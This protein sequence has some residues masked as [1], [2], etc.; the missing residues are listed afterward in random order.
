[1]P[2][3]KKRPTRARTTRRPPARVSRTRGKAR[4]RTGRAGPRWVAHGLPKLDERQRDV[5]AL[6]LVA[7]GV[8]MGFVLYGNWNGGRAGHGLA[9][10]LG[11]SIGR[12]RGL[13]PVALIVG[14]AA[15]LMAPVLP[16]LRPLRTGGACVFAAVTLALAAG[17]LGV[18]AGT[19]N[20]ARW[21]TAFLSARGGAVGQAEYVVAHRLVQQV[22][23]D[24]LVVFLLIVGIVLLTGASLAS[25]IRAT[26]GG[27]MDTTRMLRT[28]ATTE[29][30]KTAAHTRAPKESAEDVRPF[31]P[32]L[33]P[34]PAPGE[35]IVRATHVEVPSIDGTSLGPVDPW[36]AEADAVGETDDIEDA[37]RCRRR[38]VR[39][40]AGADRR[41]GSH[42]RRRG[43]G[44]GASPASPTRRRAAS[45][46][47]S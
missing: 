21:H 41:P 43:R 19:P 11:W 5:L 40:R 20:G 42:G 12:A 13:A 35:V 39:G 25:A 3:T 36:A 22:G 45:T 7:L 10:A 16:A 37:V 47:S 38:R 2:A 44:R 30:G 26:G 24:I 28:L 18:S 8:F 31:E 14:G 23:V 1:M 33:P 9:V 6:G 32:L 15:M 34:D 46:P 27:V 17:T 29:T 4:K